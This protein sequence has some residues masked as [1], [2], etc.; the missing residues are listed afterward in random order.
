MEASY[1]FQATT[2]LKTSKLFKASDTTA[3]LSEV[4]SPRW[5]QA[6]LP[7]WFLLHSNTK[8]IFITFIYN[9]QPQ[10]NHAPCNNF[11]WF[12]IASSA[13]STQSF[14]RN[15]R[16]ASGEKTKHAK[17]DCHAPVEQANDGGIG[18]V[19]SVSKEKRIFCRGYL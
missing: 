13:F 12:W 10:K 15:M 4:F 11:I 7:V 17:A 1:A 19:D 6:C 5:V 16:W 14:G 3:P 18:P 8:F 2:Q 9:Y